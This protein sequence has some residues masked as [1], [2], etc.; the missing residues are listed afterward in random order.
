ME[1]QTKEQTRH[2]HLLSLS[3]IGLA[4]AISAVRS[5]AAKLAKSSEPLIT[6]KLEVLDKAAA[7]T[8]KIEDRNV[9]CP[10]CGTTVDT[11]SFKKHV[12]DEYARLKDAHEDFKAYKKSVDVLCADLT[13]LRMLLAKPSIK[14]W[15][16]AQDQSSV[17]NS[18]S[19]DIAKL[20]AD[21]TEKSL[22]EIETSSVPL[23]AS[24]TDETKNAP[25][26]I[27]ELLMDKDDLN[28]IQRFIQAKD[29][30]AFITEIDTLMVFLQE[31]QTI[32]RDKIKTQSSMSISAISDDIAR[33]WE[34][35]H[36]EESIEGVNLHLPTDQD[37]A[38][39]IYLKFYGVDQ[40]S[41]R[42]TLSEGHRNSLGLCIF[43]AMAKNVGNK[44]IPIILDDVVVSFDRNHRGRVAELLE[45]E[46][47]NRQILLFTH[48][49]EWFIELK[50]LLDAG[51]WEFKAL[52]PWRD[53]TIGIR[54]SDKETTFD[55]ARELIEA[56][57]SAAGNEA[58]KI[59]DTWLPVLAE[60]MHLKMPY[61]F[62]EKNDHRMAHEFL[63]RIISDGKRCFVKKDGSSYKTNEAALQTL[64]EAQ[65]QLS[66]RA[67]R[68]SHSHSFT[69]DEASD[70]IARCEAALKVFTCDGCDML[71]TK[72]EDASAEHVQCRCGSLMWKYGKA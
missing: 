5:A 61:L 48:D 25:P 11:D 29:M 22:K 52:M 4:D 33:M 45:K 68:A 17:Q 3:R 55:D 7:F 9:Q 51:R 24:A 39:E 21:C 31:I 50:H 49:R 58:R 56:N 28:L 46:L 71:V 44:N 53:P 43:L 27:K 18:E 54:W 12:A 10:A 14:D 1:A 65:K 64:E 57:P 41:P 63:E 32:L 13:Q 20:R 6:E 2:A 38:I 47:H 8:G 72:A 60:R 34:L 42:L 35:L 19:L 40:M 66:A 15:K 59:M 26:E 62:R 70:L 69:K 36:P 23:V 37:K 16:D 30:N 67:N